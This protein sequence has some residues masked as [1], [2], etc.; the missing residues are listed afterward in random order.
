MNETP[1]ASPEYFGDDERELWRRVFSLPQIEPMDRDVVG[2]LVVHASIVR[3]MVDEVTAA[4]ARGDRFAFDPEEMIAEEMA[5][6]DRLLDDC[7]I[8][9][10]L[11]RRLGLLPLAIADVDDAKLRR[12]RTSRSSGAAS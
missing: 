3:Q 2:M 12:N 7:L 10:P 6:V 1:P 11:A 9:R 5:L 8:P 4:R